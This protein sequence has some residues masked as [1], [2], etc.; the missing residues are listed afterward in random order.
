MKIEDYISVCAREYK[1][2]TKAIGEGSHSGIYC[3]FISCSD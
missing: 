1:L 3:L 2:R